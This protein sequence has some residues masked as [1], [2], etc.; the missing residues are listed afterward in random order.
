M[1]IVR[2]QIF[3]ITLYRIQEYPRDVERAFFE[4]YSKKAFFDREKNLEV[5]ELPNVPCW[6]NSRIV[7]WYVLCSANCR[8]PIF[9]VE[10]FFS[11]EIISEKVCLSP[12]P[13]HIRASR[14]KTHT[15]KVCS[16][17]SP[18]NNEKYCLAKNSV[19]SE[20]GIRA[21]KIAAVYPTYKLLSNNTH[22]HAHSK[23]TIFLS[24]NFLVHDVLLF[25][26]ARVLLIYAT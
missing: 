3:P 17:S 12:L 1:K 16:E 19:H 23:C 15:H 24:K 10:F 4:K 6:S 20:E 8:I 11:S 13:P 7:N 5:N 18:M 21:R 22:S 9:H 26:K 14:K 2:I 25:N